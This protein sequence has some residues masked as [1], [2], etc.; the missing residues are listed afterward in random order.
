MTLQA[1]RS[2]NVGEHPNSFKTLFP[3]SPK[4]VTMIDRSEP[5]QCLVSNLELW[6]NREKGKSPAS[7]TNRSYGNN[8]VQTTTHKL[9]VRHSIIYCI[10]GS[11]RP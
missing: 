1:C 8:I 2:R 9:C 6:E 3:F 4:W 7:K 10:F 5:K 11:T